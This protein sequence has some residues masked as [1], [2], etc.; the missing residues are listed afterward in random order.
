[1]RYELYLLMLSLIL[2]AL[3]V[4]VHQIHMKRLYDRLYRLKKT[5]FSKEDLKEV[6]SQPQGSNFNTVAAACWSLLF[7]CIGF[8]FFMTPEFFGAYSFFRVLDLAGNMLGFWIFAVILIA[9]TA[10]LSGSI[11][12]FYSFYEPPIMTRKA[13]VYLVP[14][15]LLGSLLISIFLGTIYPEADA[16]MWKLGYVLLIAGEAFLV[17]PV[18]AGAGGAFK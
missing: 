18:F 10:V 12:G 1:M 9:V 8:L 13:I 14:F 15:L 7:V 11:L 3:V 2:M 5:D 6:A 17:L 16:F 4:A